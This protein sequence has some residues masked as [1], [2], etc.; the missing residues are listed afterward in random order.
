MANTLTLLIK[1]PATVTVYRGHRHLP[2]IISL[3]IMDIGIIIK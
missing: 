3:I 2:G 1:M